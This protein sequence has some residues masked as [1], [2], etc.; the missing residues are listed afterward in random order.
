MDTNSIHKFI[1]EYKYL[2]DHSVK[3]YWQTSYAQKMQAFNSNE[4]TNSIQK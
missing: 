3:F 1:E 4:V 2:N